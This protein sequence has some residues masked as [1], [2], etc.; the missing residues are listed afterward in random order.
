MIYFRKDINNNIDYIEF[1]TRITYRDK[2]I[3]EKVYSNN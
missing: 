3:Y 1:V 2:K